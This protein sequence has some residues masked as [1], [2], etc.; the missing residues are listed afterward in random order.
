MKIAGLNDRCRACAAYAVP[1]VLFSVAAACDLFVQRVEPIGA[2]T[3]LALTARGV[4]FGLFVGALGFLIGR[5]ARFAHIALW[6]WFCLVLAVEGFAHFGFSAVIDGCWVMV[7]AA[8]SMDEIRSFLAN[9]PVLLLVSTLAVTIGALVVGFRSLAAIPYPRISWRSLAVSLILVLPFA[10]YDSSWRTRLGAFDALIAFHLPKDALRNYGSLR[11]FARAAISPQLPDGLRLATS[12]SQAPMGLIVVGESATCR[13]W[14]LYGYE[15]PTTPRLSEMED[16]LIVFRD[17]TATHGNTALSLKMVFTEATAERPGDAACMFSQKCVAAGYSCALVSAQARWSRW[18][19]VEKFLFSGCDDRWYLAEQPNPENA[20]RH[21]DALIAPILSRLEAGVTNPVPRLVFAHLMGSHFEPKDRFPPSFRKYPRYQGDY[22]PGL[23]A[24]S[25]PWNIMATDAYDN[26][27]AFTDSV[28]GAMLE[29]VKKIRR[30][31]FFVYF[32]DHGETPRA[33]NWRHLG[34]PD[35]TAVPLVVWL[36]P[37]YRAAFP[38]VVAE[39]ER[40]S[41]EPLR[42]D[43]LQTILLPL[44]RIVSGP[45]STD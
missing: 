36:S 12:T 27:I 11:E 42:L 14:G 39:M 26:S 23:D 4:R 18:E 32:S 13:D 37:E 31:V 8:S 3:V 28:L 17:V 29:G 25:H 38:E 43:R 24:D 10:I 16:E 40:K 1:A 22:P 2:L 45:S 30:P 41:R 19:G 9:V 6:V 20:V 15:R 33:V 35:L 21:D 7:I 34:D 5:I 44:A